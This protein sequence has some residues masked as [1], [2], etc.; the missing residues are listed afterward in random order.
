MRNKNICIKTLGSGP[1]IGVGLRET[2]GIFFLL[3][4]LHNMKLYKLFFLK[5]F[6]CGVG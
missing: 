1:K 4:R 2:Q 6:L 3:Y 5:F